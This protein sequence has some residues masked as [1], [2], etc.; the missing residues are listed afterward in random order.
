ME[1][2]KINLKGIEVYPFD[3]PEQIID[4]A[5]CHP[6]I[7]VAINAEKVLNAT[8]QL[9]HLINHN[10]GYCDGI[11]P[12][13]ALHR[14]GFK[15]VA[16]VPGC[17]LWLNIVR[18]CYSSKSFYLVGGTQE[19][20]DATVAQLRNDY[21]GI[22]IVGYRNGYLSS[23]GE[24]NALLADIV[25]K[26]PDIVFVAMG[27]PRQ[28]L[29]MEEMQQH[30]KAIYQGLGGSFDVYIGRVKRAPDRWVRCHAEWLYR[31]LHQPS[32]IRRQLPLMKFA[33]WIAAKKF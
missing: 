3:S 32:R 18:R 7:L 24:K 10:I 8:P 15:H 12:V 4:F 1:M 23:D 22:N 17:E 5:L 19:V 25:L 28:E 27:S 16:K 29:L 31:L 14:M 33:Y 21:P 9:R 26:K 13:L 6:G 2:K 20:I 11:G 30:H